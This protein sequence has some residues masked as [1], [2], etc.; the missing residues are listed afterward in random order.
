MQ[1]FKKTAKEYGQ[2]KKGKTL[3]KQV[4]RQR[5]GERY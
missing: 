4:L 2:E 5:D 3:T 1:I